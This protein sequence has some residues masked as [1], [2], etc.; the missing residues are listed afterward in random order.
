MNLAQKLLPEL[1]TQDAIRARQLALAKANKE[2]QRVLWEEYLAKVNDRQRKGL[3]TRKDSF[4]PKK[5]ESIK[6]ACRRLSGFTGRERPRSYGH[7]PLEDHS[8]WQQ[9]ALRDWEESE[10][11]EM[12]P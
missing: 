5:C 1:F 2:L 6:A 12:T 7:T 11:G 4:D 3:G 10:Q 8:P 9:K